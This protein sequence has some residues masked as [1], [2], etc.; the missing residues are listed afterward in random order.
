MVEHIKYEG[1]FA[2]SPNV[3]S[4]ELLEWL[5]G[6]DFPYVFEVSNSLVLTVET[7]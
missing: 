7:S 5:Y 1:M 2:L 6:Y 3:V 4:S